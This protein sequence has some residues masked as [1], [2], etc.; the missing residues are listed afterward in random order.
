MS[1]CIEFVCEGVLQKVLE[2]KAKKHHVRLVT[3]ASVLFSVV[4]GEE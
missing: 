2:N 3:L 1:A 4:R